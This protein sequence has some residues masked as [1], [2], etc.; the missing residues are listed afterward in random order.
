MATQEARRIAT[1]NRLIAAGRELFGARGFDQ[2]SQAE[3]VRRAGVTRGAL[4]HH[5]DGKEG[6]FAAVYAELQAEI[7]ERILDSASQEESVWG[8][9]T[10]GCRAF[11]RACLERDVQR[12]V[13]EDGPRVLGWDHWRAVDAGSGLVAL[14]EGVRSA[15]RAG[16]MRK[17]P[18]EATA[19][20]LLGT[21]NELGI[22]LAAA[23]EPHMALR[24]AETVLAALLE[25]LR[26]T[27][28]R[29]MSGR[30]PSVT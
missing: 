5:F 26:S 3:L 22:W 29:Y 25:G 2:V 13:L 11:L 17:L 24:E 15:I 1:A 10:A 12:I 27:E 6:V 19:R 7:T 9:L 16:E 14:Q 8:Q 23:D 20:G 18:E 30:L 4:Y 21:M 28:P